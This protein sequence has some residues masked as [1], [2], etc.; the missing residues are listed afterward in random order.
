MIDYDRLFDYHLSML[1]NK[2][3]EYKERT[4]HVVA[5]YLRNNMSLSGWE[6]PFYLM[7]KDIDI[8]DLIIKFLRMADGRWDLFNRTDNDKINNM[9]LSLSHLKEHPE[10]KVAHVSEGVFIDPSIV[11]DLHLV[12]EVY[13]NT[14]YRHTFSFGNRYYFDTAIKTY[15]YMIM[16]GIPISSIDDV[17]K[18]YEN[19][20]G[21][22][23][24]YAEN[25]FN[26]GL[27]SIRKCARQSPSRFIEYISESVQS[28]ASAN[29]SLKRGLKIK[30]NADFSESLYAV[31][32]SF[33]KK[34]RSALFIEVMKKNQF[35]KCGSA[36]R[37]SRG[38]DKAREVDYIFCVFGMTSKI[39]KL[40]AIVSDMNRKQVR[41]V[42]NICL[43]VKED[44]R[45][46]HDVYFTIQR[47]NDIRLSEKSHIFPLLITAM[48]SVYQGGNPDT[49]RL[50]R[51]VNLIEGADYKQIREAD[52]SSLRNLVTSLS[53]SLNQ[54]FFSGFD[55]IPDD[56][57]VSKYRC[58]DEISNAGA[59]A[60]F[61]NLYEYEKD[62]IGEECV[63]P[64][65]KTSCYGG[66]HAE[67]VPS[68][69][70]DSWLAMTAKGICV[71][72]NSTFQRG[73][74]AIRCSYIMI[75]EKHRLIMGGMIIRDIDNSVYILNN[76]QGSSPRSTFSVIQ[77]I[78]GIIEMLDA[79]LLT[80]DL[81]F[82]T[83]GIINKMNGVEYSKKLRF[84]EDV[85]LDVR[86]R[87]LFQLQRLGDTDV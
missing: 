32:A 47:I 67:V 4:F 44:P 61:M 62:F 54:V 30:S 9:L 56:V 73:H 31:A 76:L 7:D 19:T 16:N 12:T 68:T 13:I 28:G 70:P 55:K 26:K 77:C 79:P 65:M 36:M 17:F 24:K 43:S 6:R 15:F 35:A 57:F 23:K 59:E 50:M 2:M 58:L 84:P 49:S 66:L 46:I 86:G 82:N 45:L 83:M 87:D 64:F 10:T 33:S 41:R 75:Y 3:E 11:N 14:V 48:E 29:K 60:S 81:Q 21:R 78:S 85:Y 34:T 27:K 80:V 25:L 71:P 42:M 69:T 52:C 22:R 8:K 72:L 1:K 5:N 20:K 39:K 40:K 63:T 18:E 53:K 37:G 74:I 51:A 38:Y